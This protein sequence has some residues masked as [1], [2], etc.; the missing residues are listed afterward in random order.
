[1]NLNEFSGRNNLNSAKLKANSGKDLIQLWNGHFK[2]LLDK[3]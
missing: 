1:M 2:E 3:P